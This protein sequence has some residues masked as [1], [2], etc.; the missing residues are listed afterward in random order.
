MRNVIAV[1]LVAMILT[2]ACEDEPDSIPPEVFHGTY[3]VDINP[4][5]IGEGTEKTD[6]LTFT[7]DDGRLYSMFFYSVTGDTSQPNF[8]D[9]SGT[10]EGYP[11]NFV[12]FNPTNI[13]ASNC[14]HQRIPIGIFNADFINHGDTIWFDK[15]IGDTIY[16]LRL[17]P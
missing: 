11:T 17:K 7:V 9:C 14:D 3:F 12:I 13:N 10:L 8:C 15:E 5:I 4:D 2:A 16:Q 1:I 6:S